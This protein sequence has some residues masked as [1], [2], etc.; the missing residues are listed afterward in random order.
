LDWRQVAPQMTGRSINSKTAAS[1]H[2]PYSTFHARYLLGMESKEK[3]VAA[4]LP[5]LLGCSRILHIQY[6][7]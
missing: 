1:Q 5:H 3:V 2:L 4:I 6:S 7:I